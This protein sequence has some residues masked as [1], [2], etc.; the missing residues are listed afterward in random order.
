MNYP[1]EAALLGSMI[2]GYGELEL[3]FAH[4]AGIALD[5]K[6]AVLEA[7]HSIRSEG[8]RLK[9]IDAL[10]HA[11]FTEKS[12]SGEYDLTHKAMKYCLKVR[13][14]YAHAQWGDFGK[15][16]NFTNP[17]E[18]FRR[19]LRPVKWTPVSRALLE[20]QEAYFDN[21]RHWLVYLEVTLDARGKRRQTQFPIPPKM[22][23]PILRTQP[24]K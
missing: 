19:P 22:P 8:A 15:R 23:Q 5:Q 20:K 1:E 14:Q 9:L 17:E 3:S 11:S 4:I 21:T 7:C 13:N 18:A 6:Y 12:L 2:I 10:A 24:R 16:L